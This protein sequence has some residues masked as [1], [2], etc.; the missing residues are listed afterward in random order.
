MSTQD[1]AFLDKYCFS[2]EAYT[3]FT[4]EHKLGAG[5]ELS[6]GKVIFYSFP[7]RVHDV[8]SMMFHNAVYRTY[9]DN[10]LTPNGCACRFP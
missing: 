10:M 5:V 4:E 6:E 7:A 3:E 1:K 8:V 9:G 2:V